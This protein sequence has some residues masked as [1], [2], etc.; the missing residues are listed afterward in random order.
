MTEPDQNI[1][2]RSLDQLQR[3]MQSVITHPAGIEA[4]VMSDSSRGVIDLPPRTAR[5][6]SGFAGQPA[7]STT[8]ADARKRLI[9]PGAGALIMGAIAEF[10]GARGIYAYRLDRL[11]AS[12]R[13]C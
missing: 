9:P 5:W 6:I 7:A 3:W 2:L 1:A 12:N 10:V 13:R 11:G 8:W 4:G